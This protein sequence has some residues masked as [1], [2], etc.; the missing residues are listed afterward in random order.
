NDLVP[1]KI[2][3]S[4]VGVVGWSNGGNIVAVTLGKFAEDFPFIRWAAFYE[5]PL[6]ALFYPPNLGGPLD[7]NINKHYRDGSAAT[8]Q[9]LVDFRKLCWQKDG[10]KTPFAHKKVGEPELR[11]VLFFDENKNKHWKESFEYAFSYATDVGL[12][13]QIYPPQ[14]TAAAERLDIFE[15]FR[16]VAKIVANPH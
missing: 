3:N 12:D 13:K 6:G 15:S 10:S 16:P 8:G 9:C 1:I 7:L 4:Q 5:A 2:Y 11:G 14:V